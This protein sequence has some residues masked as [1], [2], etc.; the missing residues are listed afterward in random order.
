MLGVGR[1]GPVGPPAPASSHRAGEGSE[2]FGDGDRQLPLPAPAPAGDAV[3]LALVAS[4]EGVGPV[5]LER[6]L[7]A[8]GGATGVLETARGADG[9]A[10]V[11]RNKAWTRATTSR[12]LKG[13]GT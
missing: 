7:A 9:A 6:L 5:L 1:E 11:R 2:A 3:A 8:L 10:A 13:F 4:V 12:G